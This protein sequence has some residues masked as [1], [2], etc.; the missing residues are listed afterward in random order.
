[1]LKASELAA[2]LGD[3]EGNTIGVFQ[4]TPGEAA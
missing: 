1:M 2:R 4:L 3:G